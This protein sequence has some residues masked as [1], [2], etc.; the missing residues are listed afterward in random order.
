MDGTWYLEGVMQL[1]L[2]AQQQHIFTPILVPLHHAYRIMLNKDTVFRR[3][4]D[5]VEVP[6]FEVASDAFNTFKVCGVCRL[7]VLRV[8]MCGHVRHV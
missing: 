8:W 6:N 4:F 2:H 7:C 5:K 1:Q 3:F